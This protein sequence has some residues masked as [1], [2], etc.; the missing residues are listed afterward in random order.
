MTWPS[1]P[2]TSSSDPEPRPGAWARLHARLLDVYG[3]AALL[4]F[5]ELAPRLG[6]LDAHFFPPVSTIA[7]TGLRMLGSGEL[8][9]HVVASLLRTLAG[10]GAALL[11]A[12]PLGLYLGGRSPRLSRFLQ[13]LFQLFAQVNAFALF[14]LFVLF[15]GIG[16]PA[17]FAILFWA[18]V[19]PVLLGTLSAVAGADPL[20]VKT[21]RSMGLGGVELTR[22]VLLPAALPVILTAARVGTLVAFLMLTAAEMAGASSGLGWVV[23]NAM[24]YNSLDRLFLA[25]VVIAVLGAALQRVLLRVERRLVFWAHT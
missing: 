24:Q 6:W 13:P 2:R 8:P 10:L 7:A 23:L 1:P 11:V 16:E 14:P 20:L 9:R 4:L 5:W 22:Q 19:W 21:A 18:C 17:K 12:V 3:F 15:F 25:A